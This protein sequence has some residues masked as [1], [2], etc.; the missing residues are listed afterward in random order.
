MARTVEILKPNDKS[1]APVFCFTGYS[2]TW[3]PAFKNS[4][5]IFIPISNSQINE[6]FTNLANE[7]LFF[8]KN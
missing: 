3:S 5:S 6:L 7:D 4:S 8:E 2:S 1:H